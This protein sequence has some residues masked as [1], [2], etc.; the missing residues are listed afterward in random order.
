MSLL[1]TSIGKQ[2][3]QINVGVRKQPTASETSSGYKGEAA[4]TLFVRGDKLA[5]EAIQNVFDEQRP[6]C[7]GGSTVAGCREVARNAFRSVG[8]RTSQFSDQ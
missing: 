5:P 7:N 1:A 6:L 8:E 2:K 3:E 4:R